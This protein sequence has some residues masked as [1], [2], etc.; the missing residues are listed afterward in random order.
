MILLVLVGTFFSFPGTSGSACPSR[1]IA[2]KPVEVDLIVR[3]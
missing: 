1:G 2:T 3:V